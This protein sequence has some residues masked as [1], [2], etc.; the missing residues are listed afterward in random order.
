M[1]EKKIT[2]VEFPQKPSGENAVI[3]K[4]QVAA[5]A[6][7]STAKE[8]QENSLQAQSEYYIRYIMHHPDWILVDVYADDGISGLSIRNRESFNRMIQDALDGKIDMIITKSLSRFAR[9]TVDSLTYI[10]KLKA[11]GVAVYF[12]R[13]NI[14]T[15]DAQGEFL[16]T[17]MSSFAEEESR[18][19]SENVIW[20]YRRRFAKGAYL[21]PGLLLGY[22]HDADGEIHIVESEAQIVRFI[23][24]LT[25]TGKSSTDICRI[26][27]SYGIPTPNN[28]E[29]WQPQ[30]IRNILHNEKYKGDA[31]LQKSV[32]IDFLTKTR[33]ENEGEAPQYYVQNGHPAIVSKKVWDEVQTVWS[34]DVHRNCTYKPLANKIVCGDCGGFYGRK[35][36]HSTTSHDWVWE[37]NNKKAGRTKCTCCHIYEHEL[38]AAVQSAIRHTLVHYPEVGSDCIEI[39]EDS[40]GS[41]TERV[42]A[43]I[44]EICRLPLTADAAV[45]GMMVS[46]LISSIKVTQKNLLFR[47]LDGGFFQYHIGAVTPLGRLGKSKKTMI[48]RHID[49][50]SNSGYSSDEIAA[51]LSISVNTVRSYL[52]RRRNATN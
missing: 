11:L 10:R 15:L 52:R 36:W 14:N 13:E 43:V 12:Q 2:R 22:Q 18:S 46:I 37:C 26:L 23:F 51:T 6:R 27:K 29:V 40:F 47:F 33:K 39:I 4:K 42:S 8:A 44:D 31:V 41:V 30:V 35:L 17:L 38:L 7:V 50:L 16:I 1:Q 34:G 5:Y 48:H 49:M 24:L 28:K 9:N 45:E 3:A 20:A 21:I 19:I 25:L 32:T